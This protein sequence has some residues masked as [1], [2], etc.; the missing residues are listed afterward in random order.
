MLNFDTYANFFKK[1]LGIKRYSITD[2]VRPEGAG[3]EEKTAK[4]ENLVASLG[5]FLENIHETI[6]QV[7]AQLTFIGFIMSITGLRENNN[8]MLFE[9]YYK[10]IIRGIIGH[11][12]YDDQSFRAKMNEFPDFNYSNY[13]DQG[14]KLYVKLVLLCI[15]PIT[16]I[17]VIRHY[18]QL[19]SLRGRLKTIYR[20]SEETMI[21]IKNAEVF[22]N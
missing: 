5:S 8:L 7:N 4:T 13:L 6:D 1:L 21:M 18:V 15:P 10:N 22:A 2:V 19:F 3:P 11:E 9:R 20:L 14:W 16:L 17:V 12:M